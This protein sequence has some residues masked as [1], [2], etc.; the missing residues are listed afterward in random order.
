VR[1]AFARYVSFPLKSWI[2]RERTGTLL[3]EA[4]ESQWFGADRMHALRT[5]RLRRLLVTVGAHVPYYRKLFRD[6]RADPAHDDPWSVHA[7]VP[8]LDKESYRRLGAELASETPRRAPLV[9]H[10]SGTTGERLEVKLDMLAATY[11]Y[12]AGLRGRSFWGIAPG[13][14]EFKIWGTGRGTARTRSESIHGTL[15]LWKEAAMGVTL[16]AP[17]FQTEADLARAAQRLERAKPKIVFGYANSI[18]LLGDY[19]ARKGWTAGPGWPRAVGYTAEMLTDSQREVLRGVFRAPVVAEYGSC[20]AGV[21]AW[22]CPEGTLHTTD[23]TLLLET[24]EGEVVVTHLMGTDFPLIRY[25]QGDLA[26]LGAP[27]CRCG[28]GL[29]SLWSLVGRK[30]DV[31]LAPSGGIIDFI[32]FDKLMKDQPALRRFKIVERARGD[33]LLLYEVY[34][35]QAWSEEDRS[36]LLRQSGALLPGDVRVT[37][38]G[39]ERLPNEPSGKFRI[40]VPQRDAAAFLRSL[41]EAPAG[42]SR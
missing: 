1:T 11:G 35:G 7:A 6:L 24:V 37:T 14:P 9:A 4:L 19:L 30:N 22:E 21:M 29:S 13:D 28:R 31:L 38:Q 20:E 33:L 2:K 17:F 41:P 42:A 16:V 39:V 18:Y 25:R 5:E 3:R 40:I 26:Q 23:D 27:G 32:V 15:K 36:R 34:P 8:M 12:V 10:T